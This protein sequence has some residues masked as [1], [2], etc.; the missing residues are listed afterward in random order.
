MIENLKLALE[1]FRSAAATVIHVVVG[2][3]TDDGRDL[4]GYMRDRD[5]DQVGSPSMSV[6]DDLPP[7]SGEIVIQKPASCSFTGTGLDYLLRNA[8]V[9]NVTV[10]GMRP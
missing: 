6:V 5:Y 10:H 1:A 9:R 3:W 8:G 7:R 2:K 4:V